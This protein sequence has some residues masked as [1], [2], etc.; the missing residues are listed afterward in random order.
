MAAIHKDMR[1]ITP[2]FKI[3][4]KNWPKKN[5]MCPEYDMCLNFWAKYVPPVDTWSCENCPLEHEKIF[6]GNLPVYDLEG[7]RVLLF[8]LFPDFF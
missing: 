6:A 1:P 3:K 7:C 5:V 4:L 8:E 2:L